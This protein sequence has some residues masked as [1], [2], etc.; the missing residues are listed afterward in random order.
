MSHPHYDNQP[1][2]PRRSSSPWVIVLIVI[3][4]CLVAGIAGAAILGALMFPVFAR[5][6]SAAR[7]TA[8]MS[9][10]KQLSLAV[11]M[12]A[13]DHDEKLPSAAAWQAGTAPYSRDPRALI[14]PEALNLPSGYAYNRMLNHRSLAAVLLP[15]STPELYDSTLG[16]PNASDKLQS[17]AP[18]HLGVGIIGYVDGH[19]AAAATAPKASAGLAPRSAKAKGKKKAGKRKK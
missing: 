15:A 5:A 14:C 17:F 16:T 9:N 4:G 1:V 13:Q 12:Y 11:M 19:I 7:R 3:G 10:V 2:T 6:R 8:C 18:R